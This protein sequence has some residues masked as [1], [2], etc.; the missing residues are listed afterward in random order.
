M[1]CKPDPAPAIASLP[2]GGVFHG[3]GCYLTSG[4]LITRPVT[5]DGGV[6]IDPVAARKSGVPVMPIIRIKDASDVTVENVVLEGPNTAGT[7][8]R[9]LVG[10]AGLDVLSSSHVVIRNVAINDTYGDGMTVS[11]NFPKDDAPT[12]DLLVNGLTVT[13]A[14]REGMTIADAVH[15]TFDSVHVR[16][17]AEDGWDFESDLNGVGSGFITVNHP[18]TTKGIRLI[19]ALHGPIKFNG[20]QCDRHVTVMGEAALS[21]AA[22]TFNG[23]SVFLPNTDH[24]MPPAGITVRGPGSLTFSH[25]A[26]GRLPAFRAPSGPAWSV[27]AGGH[28][29]LNDSP[30]IGPLG[31][32]DGKSTVTIR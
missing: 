8:H 28:L 11:A 25:V 20:C 10:Q 18:E 24:G 12:S 4:I 7:F 1:S 31:N 9:H 29:T 2:P 32:H 23:G 16:S 27:T 17:A 5:I 6:F 19:E 14:G 21:G 26:I 3:S 22:V 13:H 15:S 30:V